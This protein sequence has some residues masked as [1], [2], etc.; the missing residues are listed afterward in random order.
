MWQHE[1]I[2]K[3]ML[4]E[5][6][7]VT[8]EYRIMRCFHLYELPEKMIVNYDD[9]HHLFFFSS[10]SFPLEENM[11]FFLLLPSQLLKS[12][13]VCC[14]E[15]GQGNHLLQ[16]KGQKKIYDMMEIFYVFWIQDLENAKYA[17]HHW[18]KPPPCS[19]SYM[20]IN[21]SN[22]SKWTVKVGGLNYS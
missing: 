18:A 13:S 7:P 11:L 10:G 14:L 1:W 15:Q 12:I 21:L 9:L 17:L 3:I 19:M 4:N 5:N 22:S 2:Q 16:R 20:W 8:K 6:T